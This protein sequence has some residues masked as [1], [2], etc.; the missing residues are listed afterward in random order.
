MEEEMIQVPGRKLKKDLILKDK[1]IR[2]IE[3]CFGTLWQNISHI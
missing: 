1:K 2:K 3:R